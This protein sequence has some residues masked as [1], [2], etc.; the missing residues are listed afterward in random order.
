MNQI[1]SGVNPLFVAAEARAKATGK[2]IVFFDTSKPVMHAFGGVLL[3]PVNHPGYPD[4]GITIENGK[5]VTTSVVVSI[6]YESALQAISKES[7][8]IATDGLCYIETK[9]TVYIPSWKEAI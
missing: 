4:D 9:N 8:E 1:K 2:K 6:L 7:P 5:S 3:T